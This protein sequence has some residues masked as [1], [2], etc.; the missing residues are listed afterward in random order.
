M[1]TSQDLFAKLQEAART[2]QKRE[3]ENLRKEAVLETH[4]FSVQFEHKIDKLIRFSRKPYF[5]LANTVGKRVAI[6]MIIAALLSFT[7][8]A[9]MKLLSPAEVASELG[10]NE[11]A[12]IFGNNCDKVAGINESVTSH[13]Y[14][15]TLHGIAVGSVLLS[16]DGFCDE[17]IQDLV[18]NGYIDIDSERTYVVFSAHRESGEPI[19]PDC[20]DAFRGVAYF[21][22]YKPWQVSSLSL[23]TG[24]TGFHKNGVIYM[25]YT[26]NENIEIFADDTIYFAITHSD[27]PLSGRDTYVLNDDGSIS[28]AAELDAPHAM[29]ELP[30][31]PAKVSP[32]RV[33]S[34]LKERGWDAWVTPRYGC[35]PSSLCDNCRDFLEE[36]SICS[37]ECFRTPCNACR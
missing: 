35:L 37:F 17:E 15:L 4:S 29:F 22:G 10:F 14:V 28:F 34:L 1:T 6:A 32:V 26:I 25:F 11:L 2:A 24:G 31:D 33:E 16:M 36:M 27:V 20:D 9:A 8:Y 3:M 18:D 30:L 23:N 19:Q 7:I 5:S 13:G 21:R 12:N